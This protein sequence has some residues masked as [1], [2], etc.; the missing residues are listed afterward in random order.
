ML[1]ERELNFSA[2]YFRRED[3]TWGD[4]SPNGTFNGMV[5]DIARGHLD[6][7]SSS[8]TVNPSRAH[9]IAYLHPISTETY[10]LYVPTSG[11]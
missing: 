3:H 10:A 1:M 8:L 2:T 9:G 11:K 7:I 4:R 5:G 6:L